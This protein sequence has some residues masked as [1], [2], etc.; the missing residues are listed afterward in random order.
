MPKSLA[1]QHAEPTQSPANAACAA[2]DS[3][4]RA[5]TECVH[6][7]ERIS[8]CLEVACADA[9]LQHM[10]QMTTLADAHLDAMA[11]AYE[12]CASAAPEAKDEAWWHAAN[13]LWHASREYRRR[14][15]GVDHVSRLAGRHTKEK[16]RELALEY[17]LERSALL[18]LKQVAASYRGARPDTGGKAGRSAS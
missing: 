18:S 7:H 14:N 6:Q 15:A 16:F 4:M 11:A 17:E 10:A 1:R 9:E 8:R 5:A 12:K 13:A 2:A 3:L